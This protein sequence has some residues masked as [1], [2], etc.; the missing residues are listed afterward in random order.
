MITKTSKPSKCLSTDEWINKLWYV[1]IMGYYSAKN[2]NKLFIYTTE[3]MNLKIVMLN[4]RSENKQ[5]KENPFWM[6][7]Y[8]TSDCMVSFI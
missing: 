4:E 2:R 6:I 8:N 3:C 5:K 7:L 1:H